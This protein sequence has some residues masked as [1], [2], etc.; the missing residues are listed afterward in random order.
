MLGLSHQV[1]II[2]FVFY[3]NALKQNVGLDAMPA[4]DK[5]YFNAALDMKMHTFRLGYRYTYD[6]NV[7]CVC[8]CISVWVHA[9]GLHA[10]TG[11]GE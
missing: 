5:H 6:N 8:G 9:D 1:L 4:E 7:V 10:Q 2:T 3:N 11:V